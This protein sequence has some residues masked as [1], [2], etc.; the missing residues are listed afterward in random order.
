MKP[1]FTGNKVS[2][3]LNKDAV[4]LKQSLCFLPLEAGEQK[5]E[6]SAGFPLLSH[7]KLNVQS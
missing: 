1:L 2:V 6:A 7:Y 5:K 3:F 4:L